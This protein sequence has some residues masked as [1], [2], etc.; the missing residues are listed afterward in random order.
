MIKNNIILIGFMATGKS[1]IGKMLANKLKKQFID[2]DCIIETEYNRS[3]IDIFNDL[4]EETFREHERKIIHNLVDKTDHVIST[5]GG[6]VAYKD[7]FKIIKSLGTTIS[8]I[9]SIDTVV[10]RLGSDTNTMINRPLLD[11]EDLRYQIE[12]LL[13][14]RAY[15][16][17]SADIV[18][19]TDTLDVDAVLNRILE[20]LNAKNY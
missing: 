15:Y 3:I 19:D 2:T 4:G 10:E 1:T 20:R 12:T 7:N 8:L 5:G 6:A 11:K 18:I 17:I 9:A 13:Q 14:K 16:Y